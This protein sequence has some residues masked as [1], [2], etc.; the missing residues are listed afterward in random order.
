ML[1]S[2]LL[3]TLE[4]PHCAQLKTIKQDNKI[5]D[6]ADYKIGF[7]VLLVTKYCIYI[8]CL[9]IKINILMHVGYNTAHIFRFSMIFNSEAMSQFSFG[10]CACFKS[11]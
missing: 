9:D 8:L 11:F 7:C 5:T 10:Y 3:R 4:C 1:V 6:S 2:A